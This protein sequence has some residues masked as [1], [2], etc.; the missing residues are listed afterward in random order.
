MFTSTNMTKEQVK[1]KSNFT[2][3][4]KY[5]KIFGT[6]PIDDDTLNVERNN[7][8]TKTCNNGLENLIKSEI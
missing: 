6:K 8:T 4:L 3:T 2:I 5:F 1:M 7:I